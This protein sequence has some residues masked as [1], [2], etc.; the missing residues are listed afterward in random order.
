MNLIINSFYNFYI[1]N[2]Y[3]HGKTRCLRCRSQGA[4]TKTH[5][6]CIIGPPCVASHRTGA[7]IEWSRVIP[8]LN[9]AAPSLSRSLWAADVV[10]SV[11]VESLLCTFNNS[12]EQVLWKSFHFKIQVIDVCEE[13]V[14]NKYSTCESMCSYFF[15]FYI[16]GIIWLFTC[17]YI[18]LSFYSTLIKHLFKTKADL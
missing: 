16:K 1:I 17:S 14:K 4:V 18:L 12:K 7:C 3:S 8:V 9:S 10:K 13:R 6:S 5:S 15:N 2:K 11:E